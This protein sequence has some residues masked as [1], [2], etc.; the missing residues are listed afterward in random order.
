MVFGESHITSG[1]CCRSQEGRKGGF[2]LRRTLEGTSLA[3]SRT[4]KPIC[5]AVG[6]EGNDLTS[7]AYVRR[8][9]IERWPVTFASSGI[10]EKR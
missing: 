1:C 9:Y 4:A 5:G 10:P 2:A 6:G 3:R 7:C 8:M